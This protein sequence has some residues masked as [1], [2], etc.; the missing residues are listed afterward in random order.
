MPTICSLEEALSH[1]RSGMRVMI[2]GFLGVGTPERLIDALVARGTDN[3][4]LI[5]NDTAFPDR[6]IGKLIVNRQFRRITVCHIGTNLE[7]ARQL[8]AG[9]LEAEFSTQGSL[10]ERIRAVGAGLG[11]IITPTVIGIVVEE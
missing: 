5:A 10:I 7:S 8:N 1:V 6:G 4:I 11:G 2:S 3:L 9:E